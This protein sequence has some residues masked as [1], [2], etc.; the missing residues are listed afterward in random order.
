V[1]PFLPLIGLG[2][3]Q[4]PGKPIRHGTGTSHLGTDCPTR[5]KVRGSAATIFLRK[6][7]S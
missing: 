7:R 5:F 3:E 4:Q 1:Q 2:R 6:I